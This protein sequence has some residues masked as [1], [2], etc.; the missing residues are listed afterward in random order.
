MTRRVVFSVVAGGIAAA[1][2]LWIGGMAAA[3]VVEQEHRA[4]AAAHQ[5]AS[6]SPTPSTSAAA[7]PSAAPTPDRSER[8]PG[9]TEPDDADF[10]PFADRLRPWRAGDHVV[11]LAQVLAFY[12]VPGRLSDADPTWYQEKAITA[13]CMA[14]KG[15]YYDP[16]SDARLDMTHRTDPRPPV[17]PAAQ[18]ALGGNTGAGDAYRWQDAGC[19]GLAVHETGNDDNH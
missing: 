2:I 13:S 7:T 18:L 1:G 5:I 8:S 11:T 17:D 6:A 3:Q 12:G 10:V 9:A 15:W 16:R 14:G 4:N 19:D